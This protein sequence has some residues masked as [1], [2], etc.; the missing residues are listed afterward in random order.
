MEK[1]TGYL[2]RAWRD[3]TSEKGWWQPVVILALVSLIP[4][5]GG[6]IM[7]GYLL[8]WGREA[9]WGMDRGLP[10]KVGSVGKRLKWGFF[11]MVIICCWVI[12]L[13]IVGGILGIIPLLGWLIV[14]VAEVCCLVTATIAC[15]GCIRMT[16]YDRIKGGLQF[17]RIFKMATLDAPG[18]ACC[19]GISL[20][21]AVPA[22]VGSVLVMIGLLPAA[23]LLGYAGSTGTGML[24]SGVAIA[25]GVGASLVGGIFVIVVLIAI[26]LCSVALQAMAYR[27]FGYWVGQF[28]P[29]KWGG[30]EDPMPFEPGY[31]PHE[32]ASPSPNVGADEGYETFQDAAT[33]A[34]AAAA[35][36]GTYVKEHAEQAA[37]AVSE[38]AAGFKTEHTE[39][40]ADEPVEA[41]VVSV[42]SA[43]AGELEE[44]QG[45]AEPAE[46]ETETPAA[47]GSD[48]A[49]AEESAA[50]QPEAEAAPACPSCGAPV[51]PNH[52]FC[53][54]CGQQL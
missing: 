13:S 54:N 38:A 29:A 22:I 3:L 33:A 47:S 9:A 11:A 23:G 27:A 41:E 40:A 39:P 20:L 28:Q 37:E 17:S 2:G 46:A 18:L 48:A 51:E 31:R 10:R 36:A 19:F 4:I 25:A 52:K 15:A 7:L 16:I 8:D 14:I 21:S 32:Q 53:T 30:I 24:S 45:P 50:K 42:E 12:P 1:T 26:Q 5:V 6:L 44:P 34:G 49:G 43:N 35:A